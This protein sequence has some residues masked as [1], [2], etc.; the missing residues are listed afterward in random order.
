[1]LRF[2]RLSKIIAETI[3]RTDPPAALTAPAQ[4]PPW[5]RP[6]DYQLDGAAQ[7]AR[8]GKMLILDD[9]GTG[10]TCT[11]LLGLDE[12]RHLGHDIFPMVIIVP[13][14]DVAD[15]WA[16]E[17]AQW[18]PHWGEPVMHAGAERFGKVARP[19]GRAPSDSVFITT[20]ATARRDAADMRGP[21]VR[22]RPATTVLDEI[23]YIKND[24]ALQSR[25]ARRIAWQSGNFV[26][27][28]GTMITRNTLDAYPAL[29]AIDRQTWP[30]RKRM[31]DRFIATM[32]DPAGYGEDITGLLP[33]TLE[34]FFATLAGQM[35]RVAKADVLDELP[36]KIYSV[37]RP[38]IPPEWRA[39]YDQMVDDMLAE[40]PEGGELSVMDTLSQMTRLVQLASSAATVTTEKVIDKATGEVEIDEFT[41]Q[42]KTKQVV[43][44]RAPSWKCESMIE[45]LA[46]RPGQGVIVFTV[47]KQLALIAGKYCTDQGYRTGFVTGVGGGIT[48]KTRAADIAAFQNGDLD[49][50]ICTAGAGGTGITLTRAGTVVFLQRP[51]PLDQAIQPEGRA[52]RIGNLNKYL[53]IIDIV[54]ADTVDER[55]RELLRDKA[56][57]LAQ[58]A[59]DPRI[60]RELLGGRR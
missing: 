50:I 37:R 46:E 18:V 28:S 59:R 29:E 58:F 23:H 40:L 11:T 48:R 27:L 21:L 1:M 24:D 15:A 3:W 30:S 36:E 56:G 7:I 42:P 35:R 60:V 52:D 22:L 54:A 41:G 19:R 33:A 9:P 8:A 25:A 44:L 14:W 53:E 34:E 55:V 2:P 12:R 51:F 45:I 32:P 13:S 10:K 57:Q 16:R 26:G 38:K 49:V 5:L 39:A 20:Y 43:K 17:M 6:R 47:S 4:Y 31:K